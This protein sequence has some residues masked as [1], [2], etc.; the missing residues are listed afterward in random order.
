M[1]FLAWYQNRRTLV[2][3]ERATLR[4]SV[5]VSLLSLD[6]SHPGL[7]YTNVSTLLSTRRESAGGPELTQVCAT[8]MSPLF[9]PPGEKVQEDQS[10]PR[11]VPHKLL[12]SSLHQER[13][14]IHFR[15]ACILEKPQ[16]L[17]FINKQ[18]GCLPFLGE[19]TVSVLI[20]ISRDH[21]RSRLLRTA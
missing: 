21:H 20:H 9:S 5:S 19:P 4:C 2:R 17:N 7:C 8:W 16:D 3:Q 1:K 14:C 15:K 18:K 12:H 11:S 13:R 6:Q 10:S